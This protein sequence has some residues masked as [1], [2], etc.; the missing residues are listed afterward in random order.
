MPSVL[1]T[2]DVVCQFSRNKTDGEQVE[3][4]WVD[5]VGHEP[6][7]ASISSP[8][9]TGLQT[10]EA[11]AAIS[12]ASDDGSA[13]DLGSDGWAELCG[14]STKLFDVIHSTNPA[15][16]WSVKQALS[17]RE[18][19]GDVKYLSA[20][21]LRKLMFLFNET[22]E[23][24]LAA[25]GLLKQAS[26]DASQCSQWDYGADLVLQA[27][28]ILDALETWAAA[29]KARADVFA[30]ELA[31]RVDFVDASE[32]Q[33]QLIHEPP[34]QP[35]NS[36][37][38]NRLAM[39]SS[40][41]TT[42][43]STISTT[44]TS[45]VPA[46]DTGVA[47][48]KSTI[49]STLPATD[50]GDDM[51]PRPIVKKAKA[52]N[53]GF[54]QGERLAWL[55]SKV[56][57]VNAHYLEG[58]SPRHRR[59]SPE[60]LVGQILIEYWNLFPPGLSFDHDPPRNPSALA[61]LKVVPSDE[62][63]AAAW[64]A[65]IESTEK[66]IAGWFRRQRNTSSPE[67]AF[68]PLL[69]RLRESPAEPPKH[70]KAHHVYMRRADVK[71]RIQAEFE[72]LEYDKQPWQQH[73]SLRCKI[74]KA[75]LEKETLEIKQ[76]IEQ[77]IEETY[78]EETASYKADREELAVSDAEMQ[79]ECRQR[80]GPTL[81]PLLDD[82]QALTGLHLFVMGVR[83]NDDQQPVGIELFFT[84]AGV[85]KDSPAHMDFSRA[86]PEEYA[87]VNQALSRFAINACECRVGLI[88]PPF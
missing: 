48:A 39:T 29:A 46:S 23:N 30:Q 19:S 43:T 31:N 5:H 57:E 33:K 50:E 54:F 21:D 80:L 85:T 3:R 79:A 72:R 64:Q 61:A 41:T 25:T 47:G 71:P 74:A 60:H 36:S 81:R 6:T 68:A 65:L 77:E 20:D 62:T 24:V 53:Q 52:G 70:Q 78:K 55:K 86:L 44:T 42:S 34:Q 2:Y 88:K 49:G 8:Q 9:N 58:P 56:P 17:M 66:K 1:T 38:S 10:R 76:E 82:A 87:K 73:V 14:E 26:L 84:P 15:S 28:V 35:T 16:R 7:H 83:V 27:T 12:R 32:C 67:N 45:T 63:L 18:M 51:H 59:G 22:R 37:K 13:S 4:A 75:L 40:T 11:A 69:R